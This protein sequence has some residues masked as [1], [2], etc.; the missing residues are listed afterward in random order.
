MRQQVGNYPG[1]TVERR[2][3]ALA[4]DASIRLLDLPGLYSLSAG[5]PDETITRQVLLG[6]TPGLPRP[7]A[8]LLVVDASNLERNLFAAT[9]VLE[10]GLP[11]VVACNMADLL[12]GEGLKLDSQ[13]LTDALG[14]PVVRT[15]A[16]RGEGDSWRT[17]GPPRVGGA[18]QLRPPPKTM[19]VVW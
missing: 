16:S 12:S 19:A 15:V 3:A 1:V 6:R 8:V 18:S 5:S 11:A 7:D 13:A 2:E 10:M 14:V 17:K 9:Q 4:G